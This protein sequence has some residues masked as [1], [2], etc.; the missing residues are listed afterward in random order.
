M[1][2]SVAAL[3]ALGIESYVFTVAYPN[4]ARVG[5]AEFPAFHAFHSARITYTIGP[6]LLVAAFANVAVAFDRAREVPPWLAF[7][8][9]AAGLIVLAHTALVQV[10]AHARLSAGFDARAIARLNANEPVRAL[11][12]FVQAACDVAMLALVL[13]R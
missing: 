13:R 1:T 3:V 2:A 8:A 11:A 10:P 9:A 5:A 12:T 7:A 4:F 6:A